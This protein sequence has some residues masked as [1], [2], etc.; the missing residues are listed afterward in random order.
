MLPTPIYKEFWVHNPKT[1]HYSISRIEVD[2]VCIELGF[3]LYRGDIYQIIGKTLIKRTERE[4]QDI[5]R[6]S[7]NTELDNYDLIYNAHQTFMQKNSKFIISQLPI[8]TNEQLM[9]DT[10]TSC[11]KFFSNGY[12]QITP[13]QIFHKQYNELPEDKYILSHK[14]SDREFKINPEGKYSEF[15]RL[16]TNWESH[17]QN[18]MSIIGYLCHEYKDETTGYIIVLTEQCPDP[19][20]GGGSGKNL[21]CNLL[22]HSTTYHSKNGSQIKFDEKFFQSWNGQ[23]IMGISDV[24]KNFNFEFLKEPSTGTFIL[25]KLFK[26]EV[27][28]PV[29]DG[30]KFVIQTN[31]SYEVTDGGLRRRIIPI[32]FTDFFTKAGG[33]DQYFD[34][35]F[36]S[37][38]TK[39]DWCN[40]DSIIAA[41][42]Q[43]WLSNGRKLYPAT[44]TDTGREKQFEFTYGRNLSDFIRD[45]FIS[46]TEAIE[47]K[48]E[49]IRVALKL[50]LDDSDVAK[51]YRPSSQKVASAIKEYAKM[52]GYDCITNHQIWELSINK[53]GYKFINL[54]P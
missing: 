23:R 48:S 40:Y 19:K 4:F 8:I 28:I 35:H 2:R 44:L 50:F 17:S 21:F 7:I 13:I 25:K 43:E 49:T 32:E 3:R 26:D 20:D 51:Q 24:P 41:S 9:N 30:P 15:L 27:E 10:P 39:E 54:K 14:L 36:P 1:H 12:L 33:I 16:A 45:N 29:C 52:N 53:K 11:Y 46:W 34:C 22:S 47:V 18:I 37:G 31:Y 42:V 38:W 5:L 6:T